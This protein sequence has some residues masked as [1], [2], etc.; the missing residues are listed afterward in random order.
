MRYYHPYLRRHIGNFFCDACQRNKLYGRGFGFLPGRDVNTHMWHEVAV[1]LIGPWSIKIR[2]KWYKFNALTSIDLIT[3]IVEF[4]KFN[5]KTS[6]QIRSK[7]EQYCLAR[8]PWPNRCTHD[9]GEKF[10]GWGSQDL[11]RAASIKVVPTTSIE[12]YYPFSITL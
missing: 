7:W 6:A 11:L 1:D 3:N 4:I 10:T 8:Y 5:R 9:N 2:D 12:E